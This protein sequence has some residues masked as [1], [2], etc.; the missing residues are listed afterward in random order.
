MEAE[1]PKLT[2]QELIKIVR[3]HGSVDGAELAR[4]MQN[5]P[6]A[7]ALKYDGAEI[8]LEKLYGEVPDREQ[9]IVIM[10]SI[11]N[12]IRHVYKNAFVSAS[13]KSIRIEIRKS[14][15]EASSSEV[16]DYY[17]GLENYFENMG[18][19]I[20]LTRVESNGWRGLA[21]KGRWT[22]KSPKYDSN[23]ELNIDVSPG[24]FVVTVAHHT[25]P[26]KEFIK[27]FKVGASPAD[28]YRWA[29]NPRKESNLGE[30]G[31]NDP[32]GIVGKTFAAKEHFQIAD[33]MFYKDEPITCVYK[34]EYQSYRFTGKR[35]G[36]YFP[37]VQN[38]KKFIDRYLYEI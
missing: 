33:T 18:D 32:L 30:A 4:K 34:P 35:I 28:V 27:T 17:H 3:A 1:Q 24:S 13:A 9:R 2:P 29:K 5:E 8:D 22:I 25:N 36:S 37:G 11:A 20:D 31:K 38:A 19:D 12:A 14:V 15:S 16:S 7:I 26:E 6:S 23:Y 10:K 21:S